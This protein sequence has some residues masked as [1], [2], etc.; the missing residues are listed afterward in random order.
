MCKY[1][2]PHPTVS[3]I[4]FEIIKNNAKSVNNQNKHLGNDIDEEKYK[5]SFSE[6][7][8]FIIVYLDPNPP[9]QIM[10]SPQYSSLQEA[11]DYWKNDSRFNY[12]LISDKN[13]KNVY[14]NCC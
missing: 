1:A 2:T 6:I 12:C 14:I 3:K 7:R 10:E 8:K 13:V 11:C 5:E 9:I 4:N